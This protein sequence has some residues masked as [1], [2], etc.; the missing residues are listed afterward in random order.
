MISQFKR[1]SP[2]ACQTISCDFD[3]APQIGQT[4]DMTVPRHGDLVKGMYL[5][6]G[7]TPPTAQSGVVTGFVPSVYM[8]DRFEL[9][10]G[11][12]VI[13]T[14]YPE[15]I[16]IYYNTFIDFSKKKGNTSN[17]GPLYSNRDVDAD[18]PDSADSIIYN[19]RRTY[20]MFLPFYFSVK[21]S[22]S[23]PLCALTRQELVVR[24][25]MRPR[26]YIINSN[27]Q[28]TQN[29]EVIQLTHMFMDIEYVYLSND[30]FKYFLDNTHTY[31]Y[32]ETQQQSFKVEDINYRL[33]IENPVV[34]FF[35]YILHDNNLETNR[36]DKNEQYSI[37]NGHSISS[38]NLDLDGQT[39]IDETV[40]D[41]NFMSHLQYLL[42]H[43]SSFENNTTMNNMYVYNYGFSENPE[44]CCPGGTVNFNIIKN[45]N[46]RVNLSPVTTNVPRTLFVLVR[47]LNILRIHEGTAEVLF[48]N[49]S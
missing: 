27:K 3:K 4:F 1:Y 29:L 13:E 41:S 48:K 10:I 40:A 34:E 6:F 8:F 47:T 22:Q 26:E 23:F 32:T 33:E 43:S 2:F 9:I 39:Y 15:F 24:V 11:D 14:L 28:Y 44:A 46:L 49:V 42:N 35:F 12:T 36:V 30:E 7:L 20:T 16:N 37:I 18:L 21:T 17:L 19:T 38:V 45:K 5:R 25:H 31:M